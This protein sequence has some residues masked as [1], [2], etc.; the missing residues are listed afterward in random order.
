MDDFPPSQNSAAN[1]H[2]SSVTH[3]DQSPIFIIGAGRCGTNLLRMILNAHPRI[4]VAHE[5]GLYHVA[6]QARGGTF[7]RRGSQ[8]ITA[9]QF[10]EFYLKYDMF[11]PW[12]GLPPDTIRQALPQ[13][14]SE[15]DLP[16][17]F[18]TV[19]R[20]RAQM[21]DRPRYGTQSP[22]NARFVD[23]IFRDFPQAKII[24]V[25]RDPRDMVVSNLRRPESATSRILVCRQLRYR[26]NCISHD[27]RMLELKLEDLLADRESCMRRVL[28][29]IGEE[30][31]DRLMEHW[32]H[33]PLDLPAFPWFRGQKAQPDHPRS[34]W[35]DVLSPTWVRIVENMLAP[36][37]ERYGYPLA[38]FD[39]EPSF[40][41]RQTAFLRDVPE[42]SRNAVKMARTF[43]IMQTQPPPPGPEAMR[44][45]CSLNALAQ[46]YYGEFTWPEPN[47][48]TP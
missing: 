39:R 19:L 45:L 20:C 40:M 31:D 24:H 4:H 1:A 33:A 30:W 28:D 11:Y 21:W 32:Q 9:R 46:K 12:S 7:R 29:Y 22:L 43:R 37:F 27:P 13:T 35:Q 23:D 3:P 8:P 15:Y 18:R 25:V 2:A 34:R 6:N 38:K 14:L 10:V 44:L 36:A 26:L 17:A 5:V 48:P 42:F 16:E 47:I 41:E